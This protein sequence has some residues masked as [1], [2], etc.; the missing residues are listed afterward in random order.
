MKEDQLMWVCMKLVWRL[1][2]LAGVH[3]ETLF[4]WPIDS[5]VHCWIEELQLCPAM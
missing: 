4:R 2:L 3:V 1:T 5:L